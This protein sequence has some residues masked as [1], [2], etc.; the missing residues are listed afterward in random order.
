MVLSP[1]EP[2]LREYWREFGGESK[3]QVY[4]QNLK[5][6]RPLVKTR[7]GDRVVGATYRYPGGGALIALP[8]LDMERKGFVDVGDDGN[9]VWTT[10]AMGWGERYLNSLESLDKAIKSHTHKTPAP[11]WAEDDS[12]RS[13]KEVALSMKLLEIRSEL[14]D[15][16]HQRQQVELDLANAGSLKALLFEQGRPLEAAVVEAMRLLG[17][18]ANNFRDSDSEFDVVLECP[19]G[20]CIG[21]V[22]GRD[23]KAID[24]NKMRQLETNIHED[25]DRKEVSEPA[26]AVLFGNACR[27]VPPSERPEHFTQKCIKAAQRTN[28]AL[29]RTCDLFEVAKAL[30]DKPDPEFATACRE[31]IL[32]T[33]GEEVKFPTLPESDANNHGNNPS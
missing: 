5:R 1:D 21:E 22:E 30:V 25:L 32:K 24:I 10:E 31:A 17:F 4:L 14:S 15:L 19:E 7:H 23:R 8:W 16:E 11:Q 18:E 9:Q 28:T 33:S 6:L 27:F 3:Y 2:L 20:R 26:K 13:T 29:I 12:L